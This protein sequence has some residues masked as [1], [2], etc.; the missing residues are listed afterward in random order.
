MANS[1]ILIPTVKVGNQEKESTLFKDLLKHTN[2]REAAKS[3]WA[4]TQVDSYKKRLKG[5]Q[6]DEN[7]EPTL[8]SLDKAIDINSLIDGKTSLLS[9]KKQL[10]AVDKQGNPVKHDS[11][12]AILDKVNNFNKENPTT[13]ASI[14]RQGNGYF[15]D[16]AQKTFENSDQPQELMFQ[17]SLNNKLRGLMRKLGFDVAWDEQMI[18][19]GIFDPLNARKT[20]SNL[21]VVINIAKGI[22]GE[23]AFPEE[24][25]HMAIEGLAN[26]PLVSRLISSLKGEEILREILG[27]QFDRYVAAYKGDMYKV[28]KEAAGKILQSHLTGVNEYKP[29]KSLLQRIWNSIKSKFTGVNTVDV[30]KV[31]EEANNEMAEIAMGILDESILPLMSSGSILSGD[32][33][34]KLSKEANSIDKIAEEAVFLA[35]KRLKHVQMR[36]KDGKYTEEDANAVSNLQNMIEQKEY[37]QGV[38]SFLQDTLDQMQ[39]LH[40]RLNAAL[41]KNRYKD[42]ILG[43]TSTVSKILMEMNEFSKAYAPIVAATINMDI[44]QHRKEVVIS[45]EDARKISSLSSGINKIIVDMAKT[46]KSERFN[47]VFEFTSRFWGADKIMSL[48]KN[49]GDVQTLEMLLNFG[50][51]DIGGFDRWIGAFGDAKDA[52][53]GVIDKAIKMSQA[54]R[55]TKIETMIRDIRKYSTQLEQ[56]GHSTKFMTEL[57][58]AGKKTGRIISDIDFTKFKKDRDAYIDSLKGQKMDILDVERSINEWERNNTKSRNP[59]FNSNREEMLP[60]PVKYSKDT[61]SKLTTAQ[62]DYYDAMMNLKSQLENELPARYTNLY[63]A[64]QRRTDMLETAAAN[65][66]DPKQLLKLT[67]GNLK[68]QIVERSDDTEFGENI[69]EEGLE[70]QLLDFSGKPF[71]QIPVYYTTLLEDTDR[72]STDFTGSMLAYTAMAVNYSEMSKV[73]D[74][75]ELT[76]DL[77]NERE[78]QQHSGDNKLQESFQVMNRK[79]T[80]MITKKGTDTSINGLIEDHYNSALYGKRKKKGGTKKILGQN[81][82]MVRMS[83]TLKSVASLMGLGGNVLGATSNITIGEVQNTL[84]GIGGEHYNLWDHLK[85]KKVYNNNLLAYVA[86][87]YSPRKSNKLSLLLEKFDGLDS[88]FNDVSNTKMYGNVAQRVLGTDFA[89]IG[90]NMGEHYLHA[91]VMLSMLNAYKVLDNKTGKKIPLLDA[92]EVKK[93]TENGK[94]V[95]GELVLKEGITKLDGTEFTQEDVTDYKL[96]IGKISRKLHGSFSE[97]EK[98][99]IHQHAWGRLLMQFKQW[100]PSHAMRRFSGIRYDA[101]QD[102]YVEG[103]YKTFAEFSFGVMKDLTRGKFEAVTNWKNLNNHERSNIKKASAEMALYVMLGIG[104]RLMGPEKDR[105]GKWHERMIAYQLNRLRLEVGAAMPFNMNFPKNILTLLQNPVASVNVVNNILETMS[106][107]NMFDELEA[108]RYKGWSRWKRDFVT[109]IPIYGQIRKTLDLTNEDYLFT[110]FKNK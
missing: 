25:S 108:G 83:D 72:L 8:D 33:M 77:I 107:W 53:L 106:L 61:L 49:K 73:V 79:F 68:D 93:T 67:L 9:E 1:C 66:T 44:M 55:D 84:E 13:V 69:L 80:K 45:E 62:R 21:K 3:I 86:E 52:V 60:D 97:D 19:D 105:K 36:A 38:T 76:R 32:T 40:I 43:K 85:G 47:V 24:F 99:A 27:D 74:V 71:K 35:S 81:V 34:L 70:V 98:G 10:G 6:F 63:N 59:G 89:L 29:R 17:S 26:E 16:V 41:E 7:G 50:D 56:A 5:L 110:I 65:I 51:K 37:T 42:K 48:G 31:I 64:V 11:L 104:I 54:S 46:Y 12:Q 28:Q 18:H 109:G 103:F 2:S 4:L 30:N 39:M 75:L 92:Y 101:I 102:Q 88:F 91:N 87:I 90:Q 58:D 14:S 96:K 23:T 95:G 100:M 57:D 22:T 82:S 78:V 20:L 94:V 15:I